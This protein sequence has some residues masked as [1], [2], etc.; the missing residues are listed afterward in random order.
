MFLL[1]EMVKYCKL[2]MGGWGSGEA[3]FTT[4]LHQRCLHV[5]VLQ[6]GKYKIFLLEVGFWLIFLS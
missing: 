6:F 4:L 2:L 3:T 5:N 1:A